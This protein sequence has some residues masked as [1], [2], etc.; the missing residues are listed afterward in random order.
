V[1]YFAGKSFSHCPIDFSAGKLNIRAVSFL[2]VLNMIACDDMD[3]FGGLISTV[4]SI[5]F[6]CQ[7]S[8]SG[9]GLRQTPVTSVHDLMQPGGPA[10]TRPVIILSYD[11][12]W[13]TTSLSVPHKLIVNFMESLAGGDNRISLRQALE[14]AGLKFGYFGTWKWLAAPAPEFDRPV[15]MQG[16]FHL[17]PGKSSCSWLADFQGHTDSPLAD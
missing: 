1:R 7:I 8:T 5:E 12:I 13:H 6:C 11:A 17:S 14:Q 9:E 3:L 15:A 10:D 16:L 4:A 2:G